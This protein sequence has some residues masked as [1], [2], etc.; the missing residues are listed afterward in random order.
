MDDQSDHEKSGEKCE[1][2]IVRSM[3]EDWEDLEKDYMQLE[4]DHESYKKTLEELGLL[5]KKCLNGVAHQRYRMKKIHESLKRANKSDDPQVRATG[6]EL[7]QK[8]LGR[9]NS[10]RDMEDILPHKNGLYLSIILGQVSVSLLN[11]ADKYTY[12][13]DYEKFKVTVSYITLALSTLL[14]FNPGYRWMDAV[15]HF[16]LVWY[17]CT[18]TIRENILRINGSR[19]KGWWI[20][21]HFI[22]TVCAGITLIWPDGVSYQSFRFQYLFFSFYLSLLYVFQFFYQKGSLY[23]LRALGQGHDMDVTVEGFMSWMFKGLV[24][25]LPFLF[26]GYFFQM[27]NA[28]TLFKLSLLPQTNEWQ[29]TALAIIHFILSVGNITTTLKVVQGKIQGEMRSRSLTSKYKFNNGVAK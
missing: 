4:V 23:R 16:L 11:K 14:F 19:I 12:K 27:Y 8:V 18:L 28:Y 5:Q 10:L 21:H 15:L 26:A 13:H 6:K 20:T 9:K 25:L 22:S 7:N 17:Y 1:N 2:T 29:V 24:F 3:M